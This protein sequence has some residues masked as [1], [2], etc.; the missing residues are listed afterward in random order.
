MCTASWIRIGIGRW[1]RIVSHGTDR[2][3]DAGMYSPA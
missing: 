2:M 3:R 1:P